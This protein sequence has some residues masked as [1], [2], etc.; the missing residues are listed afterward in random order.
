MDS[1]LVASHSSFNEGDDSDHPLFCYTEV[2]EE[3]CPYYMSIGMSY[4]EYWNGDNELP[5]YY[6]KAHEKRMEN[7]NFEM[8]LQGMY[9][10]EALLDVYPVF[11]PYAKDHRPTP[12]REDPIP[13][14]KESAERK[15]EADKKETM[16]KGFDMMMNLT[17]KKGGG[18]NG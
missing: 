4:E 3:Q 2:F 13:I 5:R 9:I 18:D 6:R 7:H 11:N 16:M 12:Y 1:E 8:W 10:Y 17:K 15:R 14:T